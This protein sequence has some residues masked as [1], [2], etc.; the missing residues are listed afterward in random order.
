MK[1]GA[2][3]MSAN[4]IVIMIIAFTFLGL[5]L[6]FLPKI[7]P[8]VPAIPAPTM[9]P[10]Y[11]NPLVYKD[12]VEISKRKP[13]ARLQIKVYNY[14]ENSI[15][16]RPILESC[17]DEEGNTV[18]DGI[19]LL[20]AGDITIPPSRAV[21]MNPKLVIDKT[22]KPGIYNCKLAFANWQNGP[23]NYITIEVTP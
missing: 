18:Q 4:T 17:V 2:I 10:D 8:E 13:A 1:K 14:E 6:A 11:N 5:M 15:S 22:L 7:F 21:E 3:E 9:E 16:T 20:A 12:E 23:S 19:R